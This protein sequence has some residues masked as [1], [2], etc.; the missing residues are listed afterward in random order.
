[1]AIVADI[2]QRIIPQALGETF[3]RSLFR[4]RRLRLFSPFPLFY[5]SITLIP[6]LKALPFFKV[7]TRRVYKEGLNLL[8]PSESESGLN[9]STL[10]DLT[11]TLRGREQHS[12]SHQLPFLS[13]VSV[14]V[15]AKF[16]AAIELDASDNLRHNK[17]KRRH[18]RIPFN[19]LYFPYI[20]LSR[21]LKRDTAQRYLALHTCTYYAGS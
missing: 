8:L 7:S 13:C 18:I 20:A 19:P 1:M 21:S 14:F 5:R 10:R 4:Q 3:Q 11:S 6:Q 9:S 12:C 15:V 2:I 17:Q 16:C